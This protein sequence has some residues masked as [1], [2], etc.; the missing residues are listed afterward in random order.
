MKLKDH[1][2]HTHVAPEGGF[3]TN[4]AQV[5]GASEAE[6]REWLDRAD[7]FLKARLSEVGIA[8]SDSGQPVGFIGPA[9]LKATPTLEAE[10]NQALEHS[11]KS[12]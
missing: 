3:D 8:P 9:S 5:L 2:D 1:H 11:S 7:A 12:S 4:V 6:V 10:L